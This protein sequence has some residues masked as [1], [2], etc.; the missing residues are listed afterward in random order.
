MELKPAC[1]PVLREACPLLEG[2]LMIGR[3]GLGGIDHAVARERVQAFA[4]A[5]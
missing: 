1:S 5:A 3:P 4:E 2:V